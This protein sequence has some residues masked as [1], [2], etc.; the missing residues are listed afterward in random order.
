MELRFAEP[1]AA[2]LIDKVKERLVERY[3]IPAGVIQNFE[4]MPGPA[5]GQQ[6]FRIEIT[7][8]RLT[9]ADATE[10]AVVSRQ[11]FSHSRLAPYNGWEQFIGAARQNWEVWRKVVGNREISRIGVRYINR[12]DVPN[13]EEVAIPIGDYLEFRPLFPEFDGN[14][15]VETFAI[16]GVIAIANTPFRLIWNAGTAL[17]PLVRNTSFL[18]DIDISQEGNIPRN[19]EALW[20]LADRMRL[21]KNHIFEASITDLSRKLFSS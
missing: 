3:P 13:P 20:S 14:L 6:Q 10:I 5:A 9:S 17:S 15:G 16:N 19:D 7:G 1:I 12:I 8:H 2:E 18:L 4:I 11:N 21:H